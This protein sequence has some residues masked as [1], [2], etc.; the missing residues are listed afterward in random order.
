M[1]MAKAVSHLA[2]KTPGKESIAIE[3]FANALRQVY[4]FK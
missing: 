2:A 1:L 4:F 3:G